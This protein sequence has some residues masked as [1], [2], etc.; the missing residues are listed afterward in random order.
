MLNCSCCVSTWQERLKGK[1]YEKIKENEYYTSDK[2]APPQAGFMDSR[3]D[4]RT[5][6]GLFHRFADSYHID[7]GRYYP[8]TEAIIEDEKT[9][10][11]NCIECNHIIRLS[12]SEN[13]LIAP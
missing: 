2:Y 10:K 13:I 3:D 11:I 4:N 5:A 12:T 8:L 9:G 1:G 7:N 6:I